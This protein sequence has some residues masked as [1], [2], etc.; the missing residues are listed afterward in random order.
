MWPSF[1]QR[2]IALCFGGDHPQRVW[3]FGKVN[4]AFESSSVEAL[5]V[6]ILVLAGRYGVDRE[7]AHGQDP[8]R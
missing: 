5:V 7:P 6:G 1:W 2:S 8:G 3:D 4:P